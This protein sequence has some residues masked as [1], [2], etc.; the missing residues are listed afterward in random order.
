MNKGFEPTEKY[1]LRTTLTK[2]IVINNFQQKQPRA[3]VIAFNK[4]KPELSTEITKNLD[5]LK[6]NDRIKK[7]Y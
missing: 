5:Q 6:N 7:T 3:Y 4:N 1:R 2:D